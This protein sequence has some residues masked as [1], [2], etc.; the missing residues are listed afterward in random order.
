MS[1]L[2]R[3]SNQAKQGIDFYGLQ[4]GPMHP[5]DIDAVLEFDNK[6]I[7]FIELKKIN[8]DIPTGQRLLLERLTDSWHT[9]KAITIKATHSFKN[10][11]NDVPLH[12]CQ[13]EK[14][15]YDG[16]WTYFSENLKVFLNKL[17][18]KWKITK[19]KFDE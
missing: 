11:N 5:S 16:K 12:L 17:G 8:N 18:L 3:N 1:K 2:I 4:N 15:Y 7:I 9:K 14:F 13:V 19:L 6:A 10:D